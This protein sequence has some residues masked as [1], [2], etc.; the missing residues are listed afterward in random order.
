MSDL[1]DAEATSETAQTMKDNT[2]QVYTHSYQQGEYG[3]MITAAK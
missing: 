3:M 1:P 2:H